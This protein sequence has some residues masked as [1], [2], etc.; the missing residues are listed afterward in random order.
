MVP[1]ILTRVLLCSFRGFLR[2]GESGTSLRQSFEVCYLVAGAMSICS[3]CFPLE[4]ADS[5]LLC[6]LRSF[7]GVREGMSRHSGFG[8]SVCWNLVI[9]SWSPFSGGGVSLTERYMTVSVPGVVAL[10]VASTGFVP[11]VE[12]L[13]SAPHFFPL[14]GS[15][16]MATG[17][18]VVSGL[19]VR[20]S[21]F[22]SGRGC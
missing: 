22:P 20:F 5:L 13:Q 7:G 1:L 18:P 10:I 17:A 8:G 9:A 11:I 21:N 15:G 19:V 4:P 12:D 3:D 16:I 14:V 2:N 6:G